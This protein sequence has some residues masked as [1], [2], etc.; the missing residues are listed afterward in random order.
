[1]Q[2][3]SLAFLLIEINYLNVGTGKDMKIKQIAETISRKC[4]F[5]G[6]IEWD[7]SKPDGTPKKQLDISKIRKLGWE[8]KT[9]FEKGFDLTVSNYK[10][11]KNKNKLRQ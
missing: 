11:L 5:N 6:D 7:L 9:S 1:M 8:P 10:Y 3:F 2:L 4:G